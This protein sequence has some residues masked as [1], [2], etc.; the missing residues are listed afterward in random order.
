MWPNTVQ[1]DLRAYNLALNEAVDLA[2][3]R[4]LWR[5]MSTYGATHTQWCMPEKKGPAGVGTK[6]R[7]GL[8]SCITGVLSSEV[9]T[10]FLWGWT[11]RTGLESKVL[12]SGVTN[13]Y[14]SW[15]PK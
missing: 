11:G 2:Q 12:C 3:N 15:Q 5:L 13:A 10:H 8:R 4:P 6:R 1:R 7:A 9:R 14:T